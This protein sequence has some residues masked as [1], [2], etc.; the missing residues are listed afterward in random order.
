MLLRPPRF[1]R[2]NALF[3][4]PTLFRSRSTRASV[5]RAGVA[6]GVLGQN[7]GERRRADRELDGERGAEPW[8]RAP[9]RDGAAVQL[10]D[11]L[12]DGEAEADRKSTRLNSSH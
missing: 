12:D 11:V 6:G 8:A 2:T 1:T 5:Q 7:L 10:D 4:Y 3:P 9:R